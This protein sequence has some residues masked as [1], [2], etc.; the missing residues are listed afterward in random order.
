MQIRHS[1]SFLL[2]TLL[3]PVLSLS[4]AEEKPKPFHFAHR[5]GAHEFE[6]NTLFAFRSSYDKGLRGF[7]TDIRMTKDGKLVIL[8]DDSLDRT[9][10]GKGPV[11]ELESES[12]R[13]ITSKKQGE[14]LL[15][16]EALLDYLADKPGL[17][18]EFEMKTSN[19]KLYPDEAIDTYARAIYDQV[20][21]RKPENSTWVFTSFD[22]RPL[23][24]IKKI[25]PDAD[26]MLIKG[27]PL[28]SALIDSAKAI[29]SKRIACKMEGTTRLAVKDAQKQGLIVTGWPGHTLNDY[30]LGLGLGVDAICSDVPVM[31]QNYIESKKP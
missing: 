9:H 4:A 30:F 1:A 14:P 16:L 24:A 27:G 11:E 17:Y 6:E 25:N 8:H 5:G 18:V 13:S 12:A 3:C 15:F 10:N 22:Q 26:I 29:G 2:T 31:W 28:D 23:K 19:K 21:A 20:N 7:E